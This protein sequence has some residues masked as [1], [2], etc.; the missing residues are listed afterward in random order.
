MDARD[1]EL[2][3]RMRGLAEKIEALVTRELGA[4][5]LI[6]LVIQPWSCD[7]SCEAAEFQYISNAPRYFMHGAM[8]LSRN[9]IAAPQ[10]SRRTTNSRRTIQ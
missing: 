10:T 8:R 9:G 3:R 7:G 4:P 5:H 1:I 2:S 6:G